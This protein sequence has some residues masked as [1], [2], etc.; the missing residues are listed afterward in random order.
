MEL[1]HGTR[2]N[3]EG[4]ELEVEGER[5][6]NREGGDTVG[7]M[8]SGAGGPG[9]RKGPCSWPGPLCDMLKRYCGCVNPQVLQVWYQYCSRLTQS[10]FTQAKAF[11]RRVVLGDGGRGDYHS[12]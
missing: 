6:W 4:L 2:G 7:A 11:Q 3:G 10:A 9:G 8:E 12:T 5:E 1:P